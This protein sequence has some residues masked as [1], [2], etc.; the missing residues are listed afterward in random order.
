MDSGRLLAKSPSSLSQSQQ[1]QQIPLIMS[2]SISSSSNNNNNNNNPSNNQLKSSRKGKGKV[3]YAKK[4]LIEPNNTVAMS[5]NV[6]THI[7]SYYRLEMSIY[8]YVKVKW[9]KKY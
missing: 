9:F 7:P 5:H 2:V 6:L 8:I 4:T 3:N 1:L